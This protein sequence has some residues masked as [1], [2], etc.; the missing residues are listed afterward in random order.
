MHLGPGSGLHRHMHE[1]VPRPR[2]LRS[3]EQDAQRST[4]SMPSV[5]TYGWPVWPH[6]KWLSCRPSPRQSRAAQWRARARK[7][8]HVVP[9][10]CR[11]VLPGHARLA[12]DGSAAAPAENV[13]RPR[14]VA[15]SPARPRGRV[16]GVVDGEAAEM[17]SGRVGRADVASGK[18]AH[19]RP[20]VDAGCHTQPML[21]RESDEQ[22]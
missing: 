21:S 7:R 4:W 16:H 20:A 18:R 22:K 14:V 13:R 10:R 17:R 3:R 9:L 19:R 5:V 1:P 11:R 15:E 12:R 2:R 8:A 6:M